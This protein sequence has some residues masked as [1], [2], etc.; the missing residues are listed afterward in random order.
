L[1]KPPDAARIDGSVK[2]LHPIYFFELRLAQMASGQS[3]QEIFAAVFSNVR[4]GISEFIAP[5]P[6]HVKYATLTP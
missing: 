3:L 2:Q 5:D 6:S 1:R 4:Y